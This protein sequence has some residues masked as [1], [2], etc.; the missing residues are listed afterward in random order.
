MIGPIINIFRGSHQTP[1][2]PLVITSNV[3]IRKWCA[4]RSTRGR[5]KDERALKIIQLTLFFFSPMSPRS[6][7]SSSLSTAISSSPI[8]P[9][10]SQPG[11][12]LFGSYTLSSASAFHRTD[13]RPRE[14]VEVSG[15]TERLRDVIL[16]DT[17]IVDG[18][19]RASKVASTLLRDG[20]CADRRRGRRRSQ[21]AKAESGETGVG[22]L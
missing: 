10:S 8:I 11:I 20:R 13:L 4:T 3:T 12:A 9:S 18:V 17:D 16:A 7:R 21:K 19:Y 2:L 22:E 14:D 6:S 1:A 5:G 15:E